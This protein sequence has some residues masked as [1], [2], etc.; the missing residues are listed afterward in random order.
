MVRCKW[1][2]SIFD[3]IKEEKKSILLKIFMMKITSF[4]YFFY[5]CFNTPRFFFLVFSFGCFF[6]RSFEEQFFLLEIHWLCGTETQVRWA[7]NRK[8][9]CTEWLSLLFSVHWFQRKKSDL[10][11]GKLRL[12]SGQTDILSCH[13][14]VAQFFSSK[15]ALHTS[16]CLRKGFVR[17]FES[18][19]LEILE[20]VLIFLV[21]KDSW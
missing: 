1:I 7:R 20:S 10:A 18:D 6:A 17:I 16:S 11:A 12:T 14:C 8:S 4:H 3:L 5:S 2:Q 13:S 9:K 19:I 15:R 21:L